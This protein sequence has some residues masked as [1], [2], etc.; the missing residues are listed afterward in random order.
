MIVYAGSKKTSSIN[1]RI[2][3][4][5]E[6]ISTMKQSGRTI[7]EGEQ[8]AQDSKRT[9]QGDAETPSHIYLDAMV[10][11]LHTEGRTVREPTDQSADMDVNY[12]ESSDLLSDAANIKLTKKVIKVKTSDVGANRDLNYNSQFEQGAG[13]TSGNQRRTSSYDFT[14]YNQS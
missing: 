13:P 12:S 2:M 14:V 4:N 5:T 11:P 6:L 7:E 1:I 3:S 8:P 10:V 9:E